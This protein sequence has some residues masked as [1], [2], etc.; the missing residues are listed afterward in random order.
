VR[1]AVL[2]AFLLLLVPVRSAA[3]PPSSAWAHWDTPGGA[4]YTAPPDRTG[5]DRT[6][7]AVLSPDEVRAALYQFG[8]TEPAATWIATQ[9]PFRVYADLGPGY[10]G[11]WTG[12]YPVVGYVELGPDP[13]AFTVE[14]EARHAYN[15]A[16]GK[17]VYGD[18]DALNR[19]DL[20]MLTR[21]PGDVG[22]VARA[23]A[24]QHWTDPAHYWHYVADWLGRDY[25]LVPE[26]IRT[27][28][29]GHATGGVAP[30]YRSFL[31]LAPR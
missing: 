29:F 8:W 20:Q 31:P 13:T 15:W 14:H 16:F 4:I 28:R 27:R 23:V 25:A 19:F 12:Q 7:L 9:V 1:F 24:L 21:E 10:G 30:R 22:A 26:P 18:D 11:F 6:P 3:S 2:L 17:S 5:Q